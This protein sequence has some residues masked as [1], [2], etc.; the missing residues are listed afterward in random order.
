MRIPILLCLT[1]LCCFVASSFLILKM[2]TNQK[3]QQTVIP[4]ADNSKFELNQDGKY[5]F[6][7]TH[8]GTFAK[9]TFKRPDIRI[10]D[11]SGKIFPISSWANVR[12]SINGSIKYLIGSLNLEKGEYSL[13]VDPQEISKYSQYNGSITIKSG[14]MLALLAAIF[15]FVFPAIATL[16][17]ALAGLL[18]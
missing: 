11:N 10:Q 12:S 4:F 14:S 9:N 8:K 15:G 3:R 17:T 16:F 1:G 18:D 6:Y 13:L 7:F 2:R 5:G